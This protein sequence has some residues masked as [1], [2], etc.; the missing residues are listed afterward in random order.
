MYE[1]LRTDFDHCYN[2]CAGLGTSYSACNTNAADTIP[3]AT[4]NAPDAKL[5][6]FDATPGIST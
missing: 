4:G 3:Q 2:S 6:F 1:Y 5:A